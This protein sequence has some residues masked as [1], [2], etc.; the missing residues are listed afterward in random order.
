MIRASVR[1]WPDRIDAVIAAEYPPPFFPRVRAGGSIRRVVEISA[2]GLALLRAA[3]MAVAVEQFQRDHAEQLPASVDELAPRYLSALPVDP[4]TGRPL[5]MLTDSRGYTVYSVGSNRR[6]DG[7]RELGPSL[8]GST[9]SPRV[10]TRA[11][12]GIR[13]ERRN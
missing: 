10:S 4:F 6:D 9:A 12:V 3:R 8:G 1:P 7:G 11:D 13:I 2:E 5:R